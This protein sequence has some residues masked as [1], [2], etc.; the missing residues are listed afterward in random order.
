M[1]LVIGNKNYSSWSLRPWLLIDGFGLEF[2]EIQ[3]SLKAEGRKEWFSKYSA[4]SK[5]PVLIDNSIAI[6]DSLSICEYVSE[7]YLDGKGWPS[8]KIKRALARSITAEM[9]SGL[10]GLRNALPMNCRATRKVELTN[11]AKLDIQRVDDIWSEFAAKDK[12]GELRLF[13]SF[14]IADCFFAP[15][16]FRFKTYGIQLSEKANAYYQSMLKHP[17]MQNWLTKALAETEIIEEDEAG[18]DVK[19]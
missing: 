8:D 13:G 15:V 14:S 10:S 18:V 9:H 6:W 16:V 2:E 19:K 4:T 17:S 12:D 1:Q 3:E 7:N 11:H 5:V